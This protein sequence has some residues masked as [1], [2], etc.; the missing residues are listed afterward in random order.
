MKK[1]K[2]LTLC[3]ILITLASTCFS[4]D[5]YTVMK[6]KGT[7]YNSSK[8]KDVSAQDELC[9]SDKL[10]FKSSTSVVVV[11]SSSKGRFT[12]KSQ[13]KDTKSEFACIMGDVLKQS[14]SGNLS[15]RGVTSLQD[16]FKE[17]YFVIGAL[18]IKVE[19]KNYPMNDNTFFYLR[20]KYNGEDVNKKLEYS[21]DT[22]IF[23]KDKIYKVNENVVKEDDV[24]QVTLFFYDKINKTSAQISSFK[25]SFLEENEIK[26]EIQKIVEIASSLNKTKEETHKDALS[27][28][29]DTYGNFNVEAF[30]Q[31][32]KNNF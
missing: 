23:S 17:N 14:G 20:Y 4:Q 10:V 8:G 1:F 11:H 21:A 29:S 27:Y 22:L 15:S 2:L 26:S 19:D 3:V 9:S 7:V 6:V 28:I 12:L 31:F 32:Y 5:C 13:A 25:L 18:R 16:E 24:E 30:E